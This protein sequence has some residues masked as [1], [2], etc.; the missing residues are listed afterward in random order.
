[1]A[2][3]SA[4]RSCKH[5]WPLINLQIPNGWRESWIDLTLISPDLSDHISNW[6][7]LDWCPSDHKCITFRVEILKKKSLYR[8]QTRLFREG[9]ADWTCFRHVCGDASGDFNLDGSV[10]LTSSLVEQLI[11]KAAKASMPEI[12][13]NQ[14]TIIPWMNQKIKDIQ[15]RLR[16]INRRASS[17][18]LASNDQSLPKERKE[19]LEQ[20]R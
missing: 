12:K 18:L 16:T 13:I 8:S 17:S 9:R 11:L 7:L 10:D 19:L 6:I 1:M 20:L 4:N 2:G 15:K 3:T 5:T 14:S